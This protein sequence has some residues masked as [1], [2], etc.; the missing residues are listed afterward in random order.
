MRFVKID[1]FKLFD[2]NKEDYYNGKTTGELFVYDLKRV[3]DIVNKTI[4]EN[5]DWKRKFIVKPTDHNSVSLLTMIKAL[6][7]NPYIERYKDESIFVENNEYFVTDSLIDT[8]N[9]KLFGFD[10]EDKTVF[11]LIFDLNSFKYANS[12]I[13]EYE[14][15]TTEFE[16]KLANHIFAIC[17]MIIN[18][19]VDEYISEINS[20]I[21]NDESL[22]TTEEKEN[23]KNEMMLYFFNKK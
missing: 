19:R 5:D 13:I 23:R 20:S 15:L 8:I 17:K 10:F 21:N 12:E 18:K 16:N 6:P 11:K 14:D 7:K 2:S 3:C 22:K 9:F 1:E 4:R